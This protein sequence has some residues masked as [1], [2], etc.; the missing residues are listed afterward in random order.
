MGIIKSHWN[1]PIPM[2][3]F[4]YSVGL[5]EFVRD[6][7][8]NRRKEFINCDNLN[9]VIK[10][11]DEICKVI[12]TDC[13]RVNI[14]YRITVDGF[15]ICRLFI[16]NCCLFCKPLIC[17]FTCVSARMPKTETNAYKRLIIREIYSASAACIVVGVK[18]KNS[19]FDII[20]S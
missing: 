18:L 17:Y 20:I 8:L 1:H 9:A 7:L 15:Y 3:F 5:S 12:G 19:A 13:P 16:Y 4:F 2:A 14:N 10:L 11:T 6:I